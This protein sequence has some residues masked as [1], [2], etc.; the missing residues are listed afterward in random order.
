M[1]P[2][3]TR[4]KLP[5]AALLALM[6][7]LGLVG[8]AHAATKTLFQGNAYGSFSFVGA[9]V[10][11]E[12]TANTGLGCSVQPGAKT[13]RFV[14]SAEEEDFSSGSVRT[15]VEAIQDSGETATL[16]NSLVNGSS[17]LGGLIT[18]DTVRA[19]SETAMLS[20]G[21]FQLTGTTLLTNAQVAGIS[22]SSNPAPN[23][24]IPLPGIG[25][26]VLNEQVGRDTP[27]LKPFLTVVGIHVYVDEPANTLGLPVGTEVIDARAHSALQPGV[28]GVVAGVAFAHKQFTGTAL[29][30]GPTALVNVGCLGSNGNPRTNQVLTV[31]L[32][33]ALSLGEAQT[34]ANGLVT[35]TEAWVE[36]SA[37]V[38]NVNMLDGLI[39]ADAVTSATRA[40]TDGT[41]TTFSDE[42]SG[43]VNLVVAGEAISAD[44][45]PNTRIPIEGFGTLFLRRTIQKSNS[46][47]VRMME[48]VVSQENELEVPES[49]RLQVAVSKSVLN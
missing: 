9:T 17:L 18:A 5:I 44:V 49:H 1:L 19:I 7:S 33:P 37:T 41:T 10:R 14:A 39:T 32:Q 15:S 4:I 46:I 29:E 34:S 30:S 43:F 6:M 8:P 23:T 22:V 35:D 13:S 2:R 25:R 47:E 28:A 11:G 3:F 42:G 48:L 45:A 16:A 36:M 21:S 24:E 40:S 26:V 31:D 38:D 12:K 20:D 27:G